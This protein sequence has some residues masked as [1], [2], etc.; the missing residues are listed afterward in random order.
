MGACN[1]TYMRSVRL[2]T[3]FETKSMVLTSTVLVVPSCEYITNKTEH[4]KT[5]LFRKYTFTLWHWS[6]FYIISMIVKPM[7]LYPSCRKSRG[8]AFKY[9]CSSFAHSPSWIH[10][11]CTKSIDATQSI[12]KSKL[13]FVHVKF[14]TKL[15]C[16]YLPD[17]PHSLPIPTF[18][19]VSRRNQSFSHFPHRFH[20]APQLQLQCFTTSTKAFSNARLD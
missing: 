17:L 19:E 2:Y 7:R 13:Q 16:L 9:W 15:A 10:V 11:K 3:W 1:Q 18:L 20:E 8:T 14:L 4:F 6:D 12:F 5:P